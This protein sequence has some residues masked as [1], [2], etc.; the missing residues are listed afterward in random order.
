MGDDHAAQEKYA[1]AVAAGGIHVVIP[2]WVYD[3]VME[4]RLRLPEGEY[5]VAP[6]QQPNEPPPLKQSI[7]VCRER[8]AAAG[9]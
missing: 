7:S 6:A 3:S 5:L 4:H 1:A 8:A 2:D 9:R